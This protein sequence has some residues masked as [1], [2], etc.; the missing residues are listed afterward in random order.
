MI[1]NLLLKIYQRLDKELDDIA[2]VA[3]SYLVN[4]KFYLI[5][6]IF[7]LEAAGKWFIYFGSRTIWYRIY[8]SKKEVIFEFP[9]IFPKDL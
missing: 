9:Q 8:N 6:F 7:F 3:H 5:C 4:M 2:E 1:K